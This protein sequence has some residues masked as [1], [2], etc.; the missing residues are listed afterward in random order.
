M[1]K[2]TDLIEW[3][4]VSSEFIFAI[5]YLFK[6]FRTMQCYTQC[7]GASCLMFSLHKCHWYHANDCSQAPKKLPW[8]AS[9]A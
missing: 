1:T 2:E 3:W 5:E 6:F 7:L 4:Q 8:T 9:C